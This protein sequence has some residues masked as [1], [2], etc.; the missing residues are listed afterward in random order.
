MYAE[1]CHT[2]VSPETSLLGDTETLGQGRAIASLPTNYDDVGVAWRVLADAA[3]RSEGR[4]MK[5]FKDGS[6]RVRR[7]RLVF[8]R[9]TVRTL[10]SDLPRVAGGKTGGD[11]DNT[12]CTGNDTGCLVTNELCPV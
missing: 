5:K 3:T 11:G 4:M 1:T 2:V 10:S 7:K 6:T 9:D 12:A 8:Q